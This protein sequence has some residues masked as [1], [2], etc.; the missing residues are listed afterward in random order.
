MQSKEISSRYKALSADEMA[1]WK[2]KVD[3]AKEVYKKEMAE[4][5]KTHPKEDKKPKA[6]KPAEGKKKKKKPEPESESSDSEEES[7]DDSDDSDDSDS[8]S[9]S[10]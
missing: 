5:E 7:A 8:D 1:K 10:D 3:T 9:D 2:S 6:K 4:Y